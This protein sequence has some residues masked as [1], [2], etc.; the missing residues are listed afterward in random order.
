MEKSS[1]KMEEFAPVPPMVS[2]KP[3][4]CPHLPVTGTLKTNSRS[5]QSNVEGYFLLM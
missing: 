4:H 3:S 5:L 1:K 2:M